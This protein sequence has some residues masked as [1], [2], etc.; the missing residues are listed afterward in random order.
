MFI[1][2]IRQSHRNDVPVA[3]NPVRH[4]LRRST[5]QR[6][7]G[8]PSEIPNATFGHVTLRSASR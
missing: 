3:E 6:V 7:R 4:V 5:V 8:H 1:I 2:C